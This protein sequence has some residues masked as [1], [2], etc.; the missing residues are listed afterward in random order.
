[1]QP[2][3]K[4]QVQ[5]TCAVPDFITSVKSFNEVIATDEPPTADLILN[6]V[7]LSFEQA[8]FTIVQIAVS[9]DL[10]TCEVLLEDIGRGLVVNVRWRP[11][12]VVGDKIFKLEEFEL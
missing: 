8:G 7:R 3:F 6:T 1:M 10:R 4:Y 5:Y 11:S 2:E 12:L 9:D